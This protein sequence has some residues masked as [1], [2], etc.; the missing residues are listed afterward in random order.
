MPAVTP[1]PARLRA[2]IDALKAAGQEVAEIDVRADGSF[3]VVAQVDKPAADDG[4]L[5]PK[6]WPKAS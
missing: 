6:K 1:S 4:T 2:V 5:K 3:R